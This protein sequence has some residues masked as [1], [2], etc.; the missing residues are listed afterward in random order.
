MTNQSFWTPTGK[1]VSSIAYGH[2][3]PDTA[4]MPRRGASPPRMLAT[5]LFTYIVGLDGASCGTR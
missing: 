3:L 2:R 5:V 4:L 1:N